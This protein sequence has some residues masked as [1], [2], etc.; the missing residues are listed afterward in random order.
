MGHYDVLFTSDCF[1]EYIPINS[2]DNFHP[3]AEA[4]II[5]R[6]IPGTYMVYHSNTCLDILLIVEKYDLL[7]FTS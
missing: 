2:S 5:T 7:Y 6:S 1:N 3:V 4:I